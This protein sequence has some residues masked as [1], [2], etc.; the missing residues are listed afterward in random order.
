[1]PATEMCRGAPRSAKDGWPC[2]CTA[3]CAE[4]AF[5]E[6]ETAGRSPGGYCF[7]ACDPTGAAKCGTG[8]VCPDLG[9]GSTSECI[10]VCSTTADCP[11]GQYC[12]DG[13]CLGFCFG[14]ADCLSGHCDTY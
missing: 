13:L 11:P 14:D 7:R 9:L 10:P 8:A 5:C 2:G 6:P 3:E 12:D 1:M 4:G